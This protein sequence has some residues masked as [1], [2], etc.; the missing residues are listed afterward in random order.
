MTMIP[1]FDVCF[2][3]ACICWFSLSGHECNSHIGKITLAKSSSRYVG[4]RERERVS[5]IL[6]EAIAL[7]SGLIYS[8]FMMRGS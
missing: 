2:H 5:A 6:N 7:L 4:G 3:R 8:I 1:R